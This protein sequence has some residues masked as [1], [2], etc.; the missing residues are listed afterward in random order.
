MA[1][2][3]LVVRGAGVTAP[4]TVEGVL[5]ARGRVIQTVPAGDPT[6]DTTA[7]R[8]L[9][10]RGDPGGHWAAAVELAVA[11]GV[12][13]LAIG[14]ATAAAGLP[15][16]PLSQPSTDV[17]VTAT[18]PDHDV[19]GALPAGARWVADTAIASGPDGWDVLA[20]DREGHPVL[21]ER[22]PVTATVLRCDLTVKQ[23]QALLG[24]VPRALS[25]ARFVSG[26]GAALVGRWVDRTVGRTEAEAPWGRRGP[27]PVPQP[28]L[29]LN[30]A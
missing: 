11:A 20:A 19:A 4:G 7:H 2:E 13:V 24:E 6:P 14:G 30:P 18:A 26:V 17:Y 5:E 23:V 28:G 21:L 25:I 9:V 1:G 27:G 3:F 10:L 12:P 15:A 8:A 16:A 29:S 22:G